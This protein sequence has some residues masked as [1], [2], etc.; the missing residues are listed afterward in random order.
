MRCSFVIGRKGAERD[1]CR[2]G[3]EAKGLRPLGFRLKRA[4]LT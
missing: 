4:E 3:R 2:L 1:I